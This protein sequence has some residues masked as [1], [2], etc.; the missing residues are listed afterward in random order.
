MKNYQNDP[1]YGSE[2]LGSSQNDH[3]LKISTDVMRAA[4]NNRHLSHL[5]V[6]GELLK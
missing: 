5:N 3:T 4:L 1:R 2:H 6:E